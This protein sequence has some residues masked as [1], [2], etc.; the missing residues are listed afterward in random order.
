MI[1]QALLPIL[2]IFLLTLY[3]AYLLR[4]LRRTIC[5]QLGAIAVLLQPN[6]KAEEP[7]GKDA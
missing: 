1:I 3:V 2:L 4:R 5:A 7:H 6:T